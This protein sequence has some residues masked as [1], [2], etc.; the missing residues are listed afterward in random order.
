MAKKRR[1]DKANYFALLILGFGFGLAGAFTRETPQIVC[2]AIG[3][4][5]FIGAGVYYAKMEKAAEQTDP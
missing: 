1:S 4:V 5:S 3:L 2:L